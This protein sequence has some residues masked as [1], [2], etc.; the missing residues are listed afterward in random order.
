MF[1]GEIADRIFSPRSFQE[2]LAD[3]AAGY[4]SVLPYAKKTPDKRTLFQA[5]NNIGENAEAMSE[6]LANGDISRLQNYY[7]SIEPGK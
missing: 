3:A 2:I 7:S 1:N 5:L 4:I 6:L